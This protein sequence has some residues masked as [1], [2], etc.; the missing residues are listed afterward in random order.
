MAQVLARLGVI[1]SIAL[2][3]FATITPAKAQI[4]PDNTL[5]V[6]S[7]VTPGCVVCKID[8][9][10]ERGVNLFH[11]FSEFSVP[12]GGEAFF[13]NALQIQTIFSRVT[14]NSVSNID[15]LLRTNG[16]TNLFF[17]NPNGIIFGLNAR[18]NIGGSFFAS[19]ASSFKFPDGS[20]FSATNPQAP[21]LLTVNVTP[22]VQWGANQPRTISNAGN[23]TVGQDLTF[24]AGN[25]DLQGQLVAG[26]DLTLQATDTVKV[27]DSVVSPFIA[28]A[29]GELLVQGN[30]VVDI[31]ALNHPNSGLFSGGDMVLRSGNT[32]GGD[33]HYWSGGSF[34]I[35]TLDGNLGSLNSPNDPIIRSVGDVSLGDY[36]G[37]SLHILAGGSVTLGNVEITGTDSGDN[38]IN[39][40]NSDQFLASL[41]TVPLADGATLTIDGSVKSTLDVRAGIDWT[42]FPQGSPG[43]RTVGT[44]APTP[45]FGGVTRADITVNGEIRVSQPDGVVLLTNQYRANG[46]AGNI[47]TQDIYTSSFDVGNGGSITINSRGN[48]TTGGLD[49]YSFSF[50]GNAGQGGPISLTAANDIN[51]TGNL[52]SSSNSL[53]GNA[54]QGG[55]ISLTAA[56]DINMTGDLSSSSFGANAGQGGTISLTAVN[57]INITGSLES[58][59][60][61]FD[62][63]VGPGGAINL[64]AAN[65]INITGSLSSF[66]S[67]FDGNAGPGGAINLNAANDINIT[68]S[69]SSF[70]SSFDGNAGPGGAINLNA[71]NGRITIKSD[72]P[73]I[74]ASGASGGNIILTSPAGVFELANGWINSNASNGDGG[75]IQIAAPSVFLT[76]TIL[77]TVAVGRGNAGSISIMTDGLVS[78]DKSR[79]FTSLEA[80]GIGKGGDIRIKAGVVSLSSF[81]WIDTA[82]FGQGNA[83]NVLIEANNSVSLDTNSFI[84]SITAGQGNGGQVTVNAGGAVSLANGSNIS[85]SVNSTAQGDGGNIELTARSLSLTGGSQLVTSTASTGKAGDITINTIEGIIIFGVDPNFTPAQTRVVPVT[86]PRTVNVATAQTEN[87]NNFLSLDSPDNVNPNVEFSSRIPYVSISRTSPGTSEESF[88][89]EVLT[90]GT[91]AIFDIDTP[92]QGG[93]FMRDLTLLKD[94]QERA[95]NGGASPFLGAGGSTGNDPYLRGVFTEPGTYTIRVDSFDGGLYNLQVSLETPNIARSVDK[96]VL[97]SGLFARS[98]GGGTAGNMTINTPQLTVFDGGNI[99][100][101]AT[102]AATSSARGGSIAVNSSQINL[103]G[104]NSGLFALTEGVAPAGSLTLQPYNN[105]QTLTVNLQQG[106]QI[107]ASTSGA[108]KG[109]SLTVRSPESVSI[110]GNGTLSA[111]ADASSTGKAGGVLLTTPQLTVINGARV[112]ASTN[113]LNASATGGNLTVQSSQVNLTGGSSLSAGTTGAAPGGNLI[114]QPFNNGSTLNV[115]LQDGSVVSASTSGAGKGG[116]LTVTAPESIT[117]SGNGILSATADASST[118][119]AGGVLLSTPQLTVTNQARVSASTNSLNASAIGGN[120]T[121]QAEQLNLTGKSTIDAG[122]TGTAPGGNLLIQPLG[123]SPTLSVNFQ[124]ASV[125]SASSSGSGKG[126]TLTV[127]APESITVSGNGSFISA[128]TSGSGAGGD[129]NLNTGDLTVRDGAKVT[130]SSIGT[131]DAGNL[132]VTANSILLDNGQL[133]AETA[134]G[135]GGNINLTVKD[136]LLMRHNSLISAQAGN[137]GNGGNIT[138]NAGFVVAVPAEDSDIVADADRGNGG[139][140][141]ITTQGIF[142]LEFRPQRTPKSDITASS[143]FGLSGTVIINQLNV[144]P[145]RGLA[146]LPEETA[147]A[148]RQIAQPC[149]TRGDKESKFIITGRGGLPESPYEIVTPDMGPGN[150]ITL[151]TGTETRSEATP[152]PTPTNPPQQLVE[153][154]GWIYGADGSVIL[155]ATAPKATPHVTGQPP[156]NCQVSPT[157]SNPVQQ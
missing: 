108:G 96:G 21:P 75:N 59:S 41:A 54:G 119:I 125:A 98:E 49:S 111:T 79:L 5:P 6:N 1:S 139:N 95:S 32:V 36:R 130:V 17:L 147:D 132:N 113:S 12:T 11:S 102:A 64:N 149:A 69:L 116:I 50:F 84:F 53:D 82:T 33:A 71:A 109:G 48:I 131:G 51:I 45:V 29:G 44:V 23:L 91:R 83:G 43:N 42:T 90:P 141:N 118:G 155:T 31:F 128:E 135:E 46:L 78:L 157:D 145:S 88:A 20:E 154:Q 148:S 121:I 156:V 68:G 136:L 4:I 107:S 138:M 40:N 85:T 105:G 115:N 103:S 52:Y 63:N 13:N 10:T 66:S 72:S 57:N 127:T 30:Q 56:N 35:E 24:V 151:P 89:L 112:S 117:I 100:A 7:N 38:T 37:T 28:S 94:G 47:L 114:I 65:N 137:N 74:N 93:A 15:G 77:T 99:S 76:N 22:G 153:A 67:S 27:R 58:Y 122:T 73:F 2:S 62:G 19:T 106:S 18:L 104:N 61:S 133:I 120:L 143:N 81:S 142:G 70:S 134:S 126:G 34:R 60:G 16:T 146:E 110:S 87:L 39:P 86:S 14:G 150:F 97:A 129:L 9:G 124:D 152:S 101:T 55:A 8:G 26:R 25:L 80:G 92:V 123:E 140:I 3:G 144:D